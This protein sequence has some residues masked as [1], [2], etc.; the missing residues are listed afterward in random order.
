MLSPRGTPD[1]QKSMKIGGENH[2]RKECVCLHGH[3]IDVERGWGARGRVARSGPH[4]GCDRR[5]P[6]GCVERHWAAGDGCEM[7]EGLTFTS[8]K[9]FTILFFNTLFSHRLPLIFLQ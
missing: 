3:G 5:K 8:D 2:L 6:G 9:D 7:T 4:S 1:S